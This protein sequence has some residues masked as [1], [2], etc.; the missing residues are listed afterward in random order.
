MKVY[1][2]LILLICS[3]I[4][5]FSQNAENSF[6]YELSNI[7][8]ALKHGETGKIVY[9]IQQA[10]NLKEIGD[11]LLFELDIRKIIIS[12]IDKKYID[13]NIILKKVQS[14][15]YYKEVQL[16]ERGVDIALIAREANKESIS[17]IY[18]NELMASFNNTKSE[19]S[20]N[21]YKKFINILILVMLLK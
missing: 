1:I 9:H 8:L 11:S 15:L 10:E 20:I 13:A 2:I 21:S 12:A 18:Q 17:L 6:K 4:T 7:D 14:S 5:S 3:S 16:N 19:N